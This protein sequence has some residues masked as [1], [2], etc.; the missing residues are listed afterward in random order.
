LRSLIYPSRD[1]EGNNSGVLFGVDAEGKNFFTLDA[2][3]LTSSTQMPTRATGG[4]STQS[5][6]FYGAKV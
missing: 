3:S 1:A 2:G 6:V 4:G 5:V